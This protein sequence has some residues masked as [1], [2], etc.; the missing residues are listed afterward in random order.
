MKTTSSPS[1]PVRARR[2][3][4][5]AATLLACTAAGSSAWAQPAAYP[6][7][8]VNVITA[9]AVGSGP[10][11]VLRLVG[12]KLGQ[13]WKQPVTV[14]NRPG[15]GGFVAIEAVRRAQPDGYTEIAP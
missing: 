9:F 7:K 13:R 11:A 2:S 15:G 3:A 4:L 1:R 5:V 8:Q 12:Q 10:D 6:A 14:E